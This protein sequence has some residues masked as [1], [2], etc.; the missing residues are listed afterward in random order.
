M[1]DMTICATTSAVLGF[2]RAGEAAGAR[3]ALPTRPKVEGTRLS[4]GD[5]SHG[6]LGGKVEGTGLPGAGIGTRFGATGVDG[7]DM[8][9]D[10]VQGTALV[11]IP[12]ADA[13]DDRGIPPR[14]TPVRC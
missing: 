8:W 10:Q 14:R 1:N 6:P 4:V 9:M 7:V 2:A 5:G 3:L 13:V 12:V 11:R